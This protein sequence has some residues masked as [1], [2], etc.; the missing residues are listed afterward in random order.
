MGLVRC[1]ASAHELRLDARTLVGRREGCRI[2]IDATYVSREHAR[3]GWNG[4]AWLVRD[5][6]SRN[7]TFVNGRIIE[8][9]RDVPLDPGAELAFGDL[10]ER[11]IIVDLGPPP[12]WASR[13]DGGAVLQATG[14]AL[15]LPSAKDPEVHIRRDGARWSVF[16]DGVQRRVID[17]EILTLAGGEWLLH[18]PEAMDV[19]AEMDGSGLYLARSVLDFRVSRDEEFVEIRL[20]DGDHKILIPPRSHHYLLLTLARARLHGDAP[21]G[22]L[23]R[24]RLCRMLGID[25]NKLNV[26]VHRARNQLLEL[27]VHGAIKVVERDRK[28][29][30]VRLGTELIRIQSL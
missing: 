28:T 17:Q 29:K 16:R 10:D 3:I 5:L 30:R 15:L 14:D 21:G 11:W 19:T 24:E 9:G 26:E 4:I 1:V 20:D 25:T 22:W 6:G 8:S 2:R 27:G 23:E 18:L 12:P 13:V 7:G